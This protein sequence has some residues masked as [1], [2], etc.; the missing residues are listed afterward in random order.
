MSFRYLTILL[1]GTLAFGTSASAQLADLSSRAASAQDP[2]DGFYLEDAVDA[3]FLQPVA[4][5]FAPGGRMFVVEKRGVVHVVENGVLQPEPFIDL[6]PEVLN[7][8]DRGLLGIAVD[9]DFETNRRVVLSYAVDHNST[10]DASRRDAFARVTSYAGRAD[11]PSVADLTSRRV[12]IGETFS[13]GIPSCYFSHTIG[14][15]AFGSDGSLLVGSGDGAHYGRVDDGGFYDQCFGPG[16]LDP[17]EDIGAFRSQRLE[18]LAGKILR[19]DPET[20]L[21]YASNPFFTGNREDTASKVWA[22]GLRNPFRFTLLADGSADPADGNPGGLYIGDVGWNDWEEL[23]VVRGGENLGW[24]CYEGTGPQ[25]RYQPATPDTNGCST[26]LAGTLTDPAYYWSHSTA[27]QSRPAGRRGSSVVVGAIYEGRKYPDAYDGALFYGDY[28]NGWMASA[29]VDGGAAPTQERLFDASAGPIVDAA[30]DPATEYLTLVNVLTGRIQYVRHVD[31]AANSAPVAAAAVV[32]EQG[33]VGVPVQFTPVGSFDPDG[34]DLTYAWAFGDGETSTER[35]PLHVYDQPGV[36]TAE[37]TV[38]DPFTT[39]TRQVAVPV[40][41]GARPRIEIVAPTRDARPAVDVPLR[42]RAEVTDPDQ[43]ASTL[44][45]Q[46]RVTQVHENHLHPDVFTGEGPEVTFVPVEHGE[47]GELYFYRLTASVRDA[48]GLLATDEHLLFLEGADG[49]T[50]WTDEGTPLDVAGDGSGLDQIADGVFP[51]VGSDAAAQYASGVAPGRELAGVGYTFERPRRFTRL[52]FQEGRHALDGGWFES[53]AVQVRSG[54]TWREVVGM[55]VSPAYEANNERSYD[56][57]DIVFAPAQG[58]AIRLVGRPGGENAFVTVGELRAWGV[59]AGE[60]AEPVPAPWVSEDLGSPPGEGSATV[61][62]DLF[63]V[64]GG[65][66]LWGARDNA[67]IVTRPLAGDGVLTAHVTSLSTTPDWAK[68][69][70]VMRASDAPGAPYVGIFTSNLGVHLHARRQP[71]QA[72]DGPQDVFGRGAP[73]WLRLERAGTTVTASYS[74]DGETWETLGAV[75]VP[76]L[77]AEVIAGLAVSA[78][79]YSEGTTA[80]GTFRSVSLTESFP[81][82]WTS[83]DVGAPAG[84]GSATATGADAFSVTGG[85]DLWGTTD[86]MH[87]VS[88]LLDGDGSFV[89]RVVS[90]SASADWAKAGLVIRADRTPG[91][92]YAGLVL[93]NLGAH[94]HVRTAQDGPTAG[95]IDL[96][97]M[98]GPV[99]LRLD[100]V[101]AEVSAF[102]STDGTTWTAAGTVSVPTLTQTALAGLVVSAADTGSGATASATFTDVALSLSAEPPNAVAFEDSAPLA[103]AV[104]PVYPN[105]TTD[106]A[107]VRVYLD[108]PSPVTVEVL[109]VLGRRVAENRIDA[110]EGVVDVGIRL[111]TPPAGLYVLRVTAESTGET[112]LQQLTIVR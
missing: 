105:P 108:E 22:L 96:W 58:D 34:D 112:R 19:I 109:D 61:D 6:R 1:L 18:S 79:D 65:G 39:T 67:H 111:G 62:G 80:R 35:A 56:L 45:V 28:S 11:N 90:L 7:H 5:A 72:T 100:R 92:P 70:L 97:G 74:A 104:D 54:G 85:G 24:P 89:A 82:P 20:G 3:S 41:Q 91:A 68:A 59:A 94:V 86:R 55:T 98:R 93:S 8:H 71:D 43:P 47:A 77:R 29:R 30:Y 75:D 83:V 48:T 95:P 32:P 84:V 50:D 87:L 15:L 10:S 52:T 102:T 99:W 53:L 49:E 66:D 73:Q 25:D 14:T 38:S 88:R 44:S 12:L 103:F 21:G 63:T 9:P 57:Y 26:S 2:P 27:S 107:T 40:R 33:L 101:G 76:A 110:S 46:W 51:E 23:N 106:A 13:T 37:L 4:V 60:S 64:I 16:R 81:A 31:E 78:A 17:S 69:G 42:L 36:Y